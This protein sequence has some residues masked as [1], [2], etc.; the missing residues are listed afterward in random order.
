MSR[1][2]TVASILNTDDLR[3]A[4]NQP[5]EEI[6]IVTRKRTKVRYFCSKCNRK[7]VDLRTKKAH[8]QKDSISLETSDEQL[9]SLPIDTNFSNKTNEVPQV[10]VKESD[11]LLVQSLNLMTADDIYSTPI[12]DYNEPNFNFCLC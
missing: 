10:L 9:T 7:L 2:R 12:F 8:E 3:C 1:K 5:S 4:T 6:K 11:S